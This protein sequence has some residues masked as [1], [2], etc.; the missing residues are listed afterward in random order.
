[1]LLQ[2]L[3]RRDFHLWMLGRRPGLQHED[4]L[5][6]SEPV[7]HVDGQVRLHR[8]RNALQRGGRLLLVRVQRPHRRVRLL[9]GWQPV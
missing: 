6:R 3:Q 4:R 7:L 5:L 1:M 9:C 8:G 2:A